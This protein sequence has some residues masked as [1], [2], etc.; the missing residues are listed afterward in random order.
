MGGRFSGKRR[1]HPQ[2]RVPWPERA[3]LALVLL[4]P[5][6][7]V[8]AAGP[9]TTAPPMPS[10][11]LQ[12]VVTVGEKLWERRLNFSLYPDLRRVR[13][14]PEPDATGKDELGNVIIHVTRVEDARGVKMPGGRRAVM[15]QQGGEFVPHV[16]PILVGSEVQFPNGDPI[17]HNVF[18]LSRSATFD[19]G[20]YPKGDSRT[21]RFDEAGLV[22]VYC[23]IHSD[24]SAVIMVLDTP[25]FAV[26]DETGRYR[27]DGMPPGS[28]EIRAWHERARPI[29]RSIRIRPGEATSVDFTIPLSQAVEHAE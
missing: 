16:L 15:A 20:R 11:S 12:G 19:L 26:P 6:A 23:H 2:P 22:K 25:F 29:V 3:L 17:F 27:I 5:A 28:Y 9:P 24:M 14:E 21:I 8:D 1:A 13:N 7:I 18:S 4:V 10:G